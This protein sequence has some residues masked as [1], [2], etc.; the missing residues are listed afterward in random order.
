MAPS[1]ALDYSVNVVAAAHPD[2]GLPQLGRTTARLGPFADRSVV[3]R[4]A[5]APPRVG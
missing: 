1:A 3:G 2:T 4:E 5:A